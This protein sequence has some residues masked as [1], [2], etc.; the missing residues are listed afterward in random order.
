MGVLSEVQRG[1]RRGSSGAVGDGSS[2]QETELLESFG[3]RGL[4]VTGLDA[5][6]GAWVL[7]E[8]PR[9]SHLG[10]GPWMWVRREESA[11][12]W[13]R[14]PEGQAGHG[15]STGSAPS[16][17]TGVLTGK[18]EGREPEGSGLRGGGVREE[19]ARQRLSHAAQWCPFCQT[20]RWAVHL[21]EVEGTCD[22]HVLDPALVATQVRQGGGQ[23]WP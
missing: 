11:L 5:P 10:R 22:L 9:S 2:V 18:G 1:H 20:R 7:A 6:S 16:S 23:S 4:K 15:A 12:G 19:E 13:R 17:E 8:K 21:E 14:S 3:C